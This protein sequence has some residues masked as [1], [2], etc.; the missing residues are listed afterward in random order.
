MGTPFIAV[1]YEE[2]MTGFL[3]LVGMSKYGISLDDVSSSVLIEKY[4]EL[5]DDYSGFRRRLNE[6]RPKWRE[7]AA[8]TFGMLPN[9][10]K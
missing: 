8:S 3:Q 6:A 5:E 1:A 4:R 2:K 7:R 9:I 10:I